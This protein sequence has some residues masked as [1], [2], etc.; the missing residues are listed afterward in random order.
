MV[1]HMGACRSPL[2]LVAAAAL[3][4]CASAAPAHADAASGLQAFQTGRFSDAY[5]AWRADA[6][7]GD[8]ASALYLGVLYD[9]GFGVPQDYQRA[10][11]WYEVAAA[12][13]SKTAMF[14][15]AVMYDA[16][17]GTTA[18]H[19]AARAWYERAAAQGYGR[20]EY[21]LALIYEGGDG[22]A[23][24]RGQA[25]R[26]FRAAATHGVQAA[27]L[28]LASLGAP[29][30]AAPP[31]AA[32]GPAPV[33]AVEPA[34]ADFQRAQRVLLSRGTN[35]AEQAAE[36]FRDAAEEGNALAA[37]N[38]AYCYEHGLGMRPNLDQ[39]LVWYRR[40][41]ANAGDG[42]VKEIASA[43]VRNLLASVSHAQR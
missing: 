12:S 32:Q 43:G 39:A 31:R 15:A 36:I 6:D 34:M 24:N 1:S 8:A 4:A 10:L 22:V 9:T 21:N 26:L 25:V 14:N 38:L 40:S 42:P 18:D 2:A 3:L 41:A 23:V 7:H 11:A 29:L 33:P 20:A 19:Q 17:R 13:G 28:H 35:Q 16:G 27:R 37:Y 5:Q 30:A